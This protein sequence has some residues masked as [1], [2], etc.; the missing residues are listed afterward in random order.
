MAELG[1]QFRDILFDFPFQMPQ[2]FIYLGRALGIL[3]GIASLLDPQVNPWYQVERYGRELISAREAQ[4]FSREALL[5]WIK[6]IAALPGQLQ[7]L[8]AAAEAGKLRVENISD[9][10]AL[11][12]MERIEKRLARVQWSVLAAA[13]AVSGT[14]L[15]LQRR[16]EQREPQDTE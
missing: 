14:L 3:S 5:S 1:Q 13:G 6:P 12:R 7:R 10:A 16:R 15:Y 11:Q 9:K 4:Q 8:V 2:D